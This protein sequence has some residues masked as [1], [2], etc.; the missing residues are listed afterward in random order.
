MPKIKT[1]FK[2]LGLR[3][4]LAL[5]FTAALADSL[6]GYVQSSYLT[7]RL[8]LGGMGLVMAGTMALTIAI[9]LSYPKTVKL[10]GNFQAALLTALIGLSATLTLI[11]SINPWLAIPAFSIRTIALILLAISLDIILENLST[12]AKTGAIRGI[13]LTALNLAWLMSP[14]L[15]GRLMDWGGYRAVYQI[16]FWSIATLIFI[17][18]VFA[19]TLR[20]AASPAYEKVGFTANLKKIFLNRDLKIIFGSAL[21]L[22]IFYGLAVLYVPIRLHNELGISWS[23]IGIIFT[24]MLLPFLLFQLPAGLFADKKIGEKELLMTGNAIL[25]LSCLVIA[26]TTTTSLTAWATIL[27]ISRI[28]AALAESMQETYFYKKIDGSD[29]ALIAFFRQVRPL[30]WLLSTLIALIYLKF[31]PIA[32]LFYLA[33]LIIA[34]DLIGLIKLK[35]TK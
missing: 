31:L 20:P 30:G 15:A 25:G 23:H 33:A 17:M 22:Q 6:A 27:F 9:S 1:K 7:D 34:V 32:G 16:S 26:M 11:M 5:G 8:G 29:T 35:D 21:S 12:D 13:Y 24:I 19:K 14:W 28:G 3:I 18:L 2:R 10:L 4:V